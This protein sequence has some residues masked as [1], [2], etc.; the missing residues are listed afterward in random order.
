MKRSFTLIRKAVTLIAL[1][2][3]VMWFGFASN[4][5]G[6]SAAVCCSFCERPVDIPICIDKP[7]AAICECGKRC[8]P[9]C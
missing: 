7:E 3:G 1:L 8:S 6:T 2:A 9:L 5:S 4:Q